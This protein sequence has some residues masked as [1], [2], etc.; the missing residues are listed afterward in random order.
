M[1]LRLLLTKLVRTGHKHH[2]GYIHMK[3]DVHYDVFP[4]NDWTQWKYI[5]NWDFSKTH[6]LF[7]HPAISVLAKHTNVSFHEIHNN[8]IDTL[9]ECIIHYWVQDILSRQDEIHED[10]Y[11]MIDIFHSVHTFHLY[12]YPSFREWFVRFRETSSDKYDSYKD[13]IIENGL[14]DN[15]DENDIAFWQD[16]DFQHTIKKPLLDILTLIITNLIIRHNYQPRREN[17]ND[18]LVEEY[19][20]DCTPEERYNV[21]KQDDMHREKDLIQ[22]RIQQHDNVYLLMIILYPADN[23]PS[24]LHDEMVYMNYIQKITNYENTQEQSLVLSK[25]LLYDIDE[26]DIRKALLS[27]LEYDAL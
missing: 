21:S 18:A 9:K 11:N 6:G 13:C 5:D 16:I 8:P 24:Y 12:N 15:P 4:H 10:L 7:Q 27:F 20:Y 17:I 23:L 22:H 26:S 14:E 2:R 1:T 3:S 25:K 19:R